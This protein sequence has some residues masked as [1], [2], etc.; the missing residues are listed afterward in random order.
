VRSHAQK[1]FQR[2]TQ[3]KESGKIGENDFQF[4]MDGKRMFKSAKKRVLE[5]QK[6][7]KTGAQRTDQR[8]D[9]RPVGWY[10]SPYYSEVMTKTES[11]VNLDLKSF[12]DKCQSSF[13]WASVKQAQG[14]H[15]RKSGGS[16]YTHTTS[17][18]FQK[19]SIEGFR[20]P[21]EMKDGCNLYRIPKMSIA[22]LNY[23]NYTDCNLTTTATERY[24]IVST[25]AEASRAV[26]LSKQENVV[27]SIE[28]SE[29]RNEIAELKQGEEE[30]M[31]PEQE[32]WKY[33]LT[34]FSS[35]ELTIFMQACLTT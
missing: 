23:R 10:S 13:L 2:I 16:T 7:S 31:E 22:R 30:K 34:H 14:G 24:G 26:F 8:R 15:S 27:K 35:E 11:K 9:A 33:A 25:H 3:A 5:G 6:E 20:A 29:P 4:M 12:E 32:F 17:L 19:E 18:E 21:Y 28:N 1:Y